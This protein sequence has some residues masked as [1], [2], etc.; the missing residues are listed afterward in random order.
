MAPVGSR[1]LVEPHVGRTV[2]LGGVGVVHK[3]TGELTD[4]ALSIVEHPVQPGTLVPPHVHRSEDELSYVVEGSFGVR[5]GDAIFEAAPGSY[6]FKPRNV[7]HTFWNAGPRLA[8]LIEIIWPSHFEHF[9]DELAAAYEAGGGTPHPE[10]IRQLG[11]RYDVEFLMDCV[12]ELEQRFG[13]SVIHR[14]GQ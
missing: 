1:L 2:H 8:R 5:I 11:E 14:G 13:V 10:T 6:V 9:F 12:P 3:V 7:Q 4:G